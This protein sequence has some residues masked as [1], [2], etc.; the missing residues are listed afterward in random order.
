MANPLLNH[1]LLDYAHFKAANRLLHRLWSQA[2]GQP[3]YDKRDWQALAEAL[4]I[5]ALYGPGP[6]RPAADSE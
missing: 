4:H 2:V 1:A 5:L 3:D 6:A